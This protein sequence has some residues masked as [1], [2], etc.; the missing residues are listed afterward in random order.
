MNKINKG[1]D[2]FTGTA[3]PE[4]ASEV[5]EILGIERVSQQGRSRKFRQL[6]VGETHRQQYGVNLQILSSSAYDITN[7][8]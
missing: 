6:P 5:S 7:P 8:L 3:N 2:I 1:L 4:F